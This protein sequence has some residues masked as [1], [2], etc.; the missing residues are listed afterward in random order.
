MLRTL[1]DLKR[2]TIGA[3]DGE[4]GKVRDA[5][6]D[7][8]H[9]AVRYLVVDTGG[10]LSGRKVL[11][12]PLS[13]GEGD[14]ENRVLHVRLT[15]DQVK[16]A[17]DIDTD[18]PVSRQRE[19]EF[20]DHY[21]YPYYWAGPAMWGPTSFPAGTEAALGQIPP[22]VEPERL[23]RREQESH[24]PHLRSANEVSGYGIEAADGG[25]GH[26]DDFLF[27]DEDW[28]LRYLV[29]D[30]RNWLPGRQ[31]LLSTEWV[32]EVSWSER[33][34]YVGLSREEVRSSPEYDRRLMISETEEERL[35]RHYNREPRR[36]GTR[37]QIR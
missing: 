11:I 9:W 22:P 30:T 33:K 4:I 24:D 16:N 20:F 15:R 29:V 17:P 6:F 28:A 32:D 35:Y 34:A 3:T 12:T 27:D 21:G 18:K 10:W 8:H 37:V 5:F 26:I 19:S 36:S 25:I 7:D 31:V 14:W 23:A 2:M 13:V 1:R